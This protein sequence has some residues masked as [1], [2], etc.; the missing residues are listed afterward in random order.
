VTATPLEAARR[1]HADG[2]APALLLSA[3]REPFGARSLL[4]C[5]P[6]E[7]VV[8]PAEAGAGLPALPPRL[9]HGAHGHGLW[10]GAL[11]YDAGL[12]LLGLAGRHAPVVPACVALYHETYAVYGHDAGTWTLVGPGGPA[13]DLLEGAIATPVGPTPTPTPLTP[14]QA[15]SASTRATYAARCAE[16]QRLIGLG[17]VFELNLTHVVETPWD[18]DGFALFERLLAEAPADHA[19]YLATDGLVLASVSPEVFLRIEDGV[20]EARPI[21]GTRRRGATPAE[22]DRLARELAASDKDRAENVMIVDLLRHDLTATAVPGSVVVSELCTV[23]RTPGT[24]HL[25]SAIRARVRPDVRLPDVL[26]SCFPGGSITGAP[27]RRAME[28]IDRLEETPRGLYCGTIFAWEPAERRLVS[29]IAIRTATVAGGRARYGAGGA[30]TLLSVPDV[31][32][33]E[34]LVKARPFLLATAST[35]QGW[36]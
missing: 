6:D 34:T 10:V 21:K 7:T 28:L 2:H 19:A 20:A 23:E 24:M 27:K 11:S 29:S 33:D 9:V 4:A 17:E 26:L 13:R 22:D 16:V 3:R 32:A 15:T 18:E 8:L 35:L 30:V 25:V 1:L 36:E 5:R 14:R 12:P 31:E